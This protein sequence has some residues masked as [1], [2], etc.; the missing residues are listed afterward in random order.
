LKLWAKVGACV[1]V[2][3][4]SFLAFDRLLFTIVR[5]SASYHYASLRKDDYTFRWSLGKGDG[6]LLI[7]GSSR[8]MVALRNYFLSIRL[9]KRVILEAEE[10][11]FPRYYYYFYQKYR[12]SFRKP[13]VVL[14]GVDYFMFGLKSYPAQ[15]ARLGKEIQMETLDLALAVN[16]RSSLLSRIS[17]LYRKKPDMDNY[18]IDLL[19]LKGESGIENTADSSL[20]KNSGRGQA[21]RGDVSKRRTYITIKPKRWETCAYWKFPGEEGAYLERLLTALEREDVPVILLIIPDYV[22]TNETNFEQDE[23]KSDIKALAA[24]HRRVFVLDFNRTE[25]FNLNDPELFV[26]GGWGRSNCH[27]SQEG[28]R[29]LTRMVTARVRKV[30]EE[31]RKRELSGKDK[32]R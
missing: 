6:E 28:R 22:G 13:K 16:N 29:I 19:Q 23:F 15:L 18:L 2:F 1:L 5:K 20:A 27:L 12:K 14:Y 3:S 32:A 25:R 17:W 8:A 24:R 9:N 10:G 30:L 4:A 26:N 11:K 31:T 21:G 7:F